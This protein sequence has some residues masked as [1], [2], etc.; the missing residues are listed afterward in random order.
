MEYSIL[1]N[2]EIQESATTI[3]IRRII[4]LI[5]AIFIQNI[6][7]IIE[8]HVQ[9]ILIT[10]LLT[11]EI[12]MIILVIDQIDHIILLLVLITIVLVEQVREVQ[13]VHDNNTFYLKDNFE[14]L[15][16]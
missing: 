15:L 1:T 7:V 12:D 14:T 3:I 11:L 16:T 8:G 13:G 2:L 4:A 9:I 5:V 6:E 10:I